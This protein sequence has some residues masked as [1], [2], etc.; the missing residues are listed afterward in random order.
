MFQKNAEAYFLV[1]LYIILC[2]YIFKL[3]AAVPPINVFNLEPCTYTFFNL[4]G[5]NIGCIVH[6]LTGSG[7]HILAWPKSAPEK[8]LT[9][10]F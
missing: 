1:L 7:L 3:G 6:V 10:L 8:T 4:E 5:I 9:K 2:S